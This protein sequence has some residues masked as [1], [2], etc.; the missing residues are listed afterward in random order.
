VVATFDLDQCVEVL[1]RTPQVVRELLAGLPADWTRHNEGGDTW[2]PYDVVGHLIHGEKADWIPRLE[3]ILGPGADKR[4]P[5]FD[6]LAQFHDSGGRSLEDLI[7]EFGE[8]RR[9]SLERLRSF[10]LTEA[11]FDRSGVHPE[12]G[13]VTL[14]QLLATWVA[15]DLDHIVQIARVMAK[16]MVGEVGPWI[17]YLRVLRD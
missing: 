12:F 6:R 9:A 15:H 8:R 16:Q 17:A 1:E 2:S 13:P 4:F 10:Q 14:R 11:D 3:I 5:P 7:E